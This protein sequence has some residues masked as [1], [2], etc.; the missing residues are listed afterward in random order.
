MESVKK[1][2]NSVRKM[3]GVL[4]LFSLLLV[5]SGCKAMDYKQAQE[6]YTQGKY[7]EAANMFITLGEYKDSAEM[8]NESMYS[9]ATSW[10]DDGAYEDAEAAFTFLGEYKDS[11]EMAKKSKCSYALTLCEAGDYES[12]IAILDNLE[13]YEPAIESRTMVQYQYANTLLAEKEYD[14]ALEHFKECADYQDTE[15]ILDKTA[16]ELRAQEEYRLCLSYLYLHNDEEEEKQQIYYDYLTWQMQNYNY[17]DTAETYRKVKDYRDV[18]ENDMFA[19]ARLLAAD[20]ISYSDSEISGYIYIT[21]TTILLDLDFT[22]E[23]MTFSCTIGKANMYSAEE[24]IIVT[25]GFPYR[26]NGRDILYQ[27]T[28]GDYLVGGTIGEFAPQ[29]DTESKGTVTLNLDL[30]ECMSVTDVPFEL[31]E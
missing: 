17:T 23:E 10:L 18:A 13:D 11:A 15:E 12:A 4:V 19:G 25:K 28:A 8:F 14:A 7:E 29:K 24:P 31:A 1:S 9:L 20:D 2:H 21:V 27:N 22:P 16:A 30:P 6:L 26:F 5:L 3:A